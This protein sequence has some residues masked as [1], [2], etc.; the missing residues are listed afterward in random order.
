MLVA[1]IWM[2]AVSKELGIPLHALQE[3]NMY[4]KGAVT[5]FGQEIVHNRLP[6]CWQRVTETS[7]YHNRRR[8]VDKFNAAT[9]YGSCANGH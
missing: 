1:G 9:R 5:H 7:D 6:V 3:R 2:D 8:S 4:G